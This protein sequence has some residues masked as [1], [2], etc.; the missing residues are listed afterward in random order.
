MI[1]KY[2]RAVLTLV[3]LGWDFPLLKWW[4][5]RPRVVA[6]RERR[7]AALRVIVRPVVRLVKLIVKVALLPVKFV[8]WR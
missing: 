2:L 3:T 6:R 8:L 7:R 4:W 5:N 1:R